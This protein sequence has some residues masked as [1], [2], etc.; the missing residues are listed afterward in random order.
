MSS[1]SPKFIQLLSDVLDEHRRTLRP[2]VSLADNRILQQ[3]LT[4]R[5]IQLA[6]KQWPGFADFLGTL[7]QHEKEQTERKG[8]RA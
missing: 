3:A 6:D 5:M 2:D 1:Y 4:D 8:A 7:M